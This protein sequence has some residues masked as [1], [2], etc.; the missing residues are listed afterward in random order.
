MK[1]QKLTPSEYSF[2][3]WEHPESHM[4]RPTIEVHGLMNVISRLIFTSIIVK[5]DHCISKH[6]TSIFSLP[7]IVHRMLLV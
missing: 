4:K 6:P 2:F 5:L 1:V 7:T 3:E